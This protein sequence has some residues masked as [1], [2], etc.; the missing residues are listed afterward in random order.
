MKKMK[1]VRN[2][3]SM[4]ELTVVISVLAIMLVAITNILVNSFRARSRSEIGDK[5][6]QNGNAVLAEIKYN[7]LNSDGDNVNC[8]WAGSGGIGTSMSYVNQNDGQT[9][10]INCIE[11]VKIA[12]QSGIIDRR[13]SSEDVIV[14]G[15]DIFVNCEQ[16]PSSP[17]VMSVANFRF[18]MS[19]ATFPSIGI[20]E[21]IS[22]IFETKVVVR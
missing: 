3:F 6:E 10:T 2:G 5:L 21:T 1:E 15:C 16:L 7:V 8:S 9:T 11:G 13:L 22:R 12:S 4:I 18:V 20:A 19:N 14:S 17:G